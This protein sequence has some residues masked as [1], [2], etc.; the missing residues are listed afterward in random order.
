MDETWKEEVGEL[1]MF[2]TSKLCITIF[3]GRE[4]DLCS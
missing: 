3:P 2:S 1:F 4:H